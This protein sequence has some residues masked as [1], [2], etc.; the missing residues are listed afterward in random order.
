MVSLGRRTHHS[1]RAR[2]VGRAC[3]AARSPHLQGRA[4]PRSPRR[5]SWIGRWFS[6]GSM[7]RRMPWPSPWPRVAST[8]R[9]GRTSRGCTSWWSACGATPRPW[10]CSKRREG[11][12][13]PWWPGAPP[14]ACPSSW[15]IH[16]RCATLPARS[17]GWRRPMRSTR[18]C[19]RSSPNGCSPRCGPCPMRPPG[20]S[21]LS[22]PG[23]ASSSRCSSPSSSGCSGRAGGGPRRPDAHR[24]AQEAPRGTG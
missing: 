13:R 6:S 12:R 22:W 9:V 5:E 23:G 20:S 14:L 16:G 1:W 7:S 19:S 4:R 18:A 15:S 21:A 2:T 10:S 3:G 24:L 11:S 17:A 8:G